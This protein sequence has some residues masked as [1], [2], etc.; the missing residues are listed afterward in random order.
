VTPFAPFVLPVTAVIGAFAVAI[1]AMI[2]KGRALD[3]QHR[4]RLFLAEKGLEIPKELYQVQKEPRPRSNG[5]KAARAWLMVLGTMLIFVGFGVM[6][7]VGVSE[8]MD[9]G[10]NGVIPL[11]IGV[12]F[13]V[14]ERMIARSLVK[15][16]QG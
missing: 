16:A 2:L 7:A 11:L 10:I 3:R 4:E 14:A 13:L 6:I 1:T 5:F 9:S 15:E 8:G 12:G